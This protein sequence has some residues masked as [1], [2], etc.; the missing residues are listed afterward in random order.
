M[1][2]DFRDNEIMAY[3]FR[4]TYDLLE[5][6]FTGVLHMRFDT[7]PN[8]MN[9][10]VLRGAKTIS[11]QGEFPE[12]QEELEEQAGWEQPEIK[13][14]NDVWNRFNDVIVLAWTDAQN[15]EH[16]R[17]FT[18]SGDPG[19]VTRARYLRTVQWLHG[20]G[21]VAQGQHTATWGNVPIQRRLTYIDIAAYTQEGN[22][23]AA[24]WG[25]RLQW[26]NGEKYYTLAPVLETQI[27]GAGPVERAGR[28]RFIGDAT[29]GC[30]VYCGGAGDQGELYDAIWGWYG[31]ENNTFNVLVWKA[32]DLYRWQRDGRFNPRDFRP[33]LDFATRDWSN[34]PAQRRVEQIQRLIE[35]RTG[36]E[37]QDE[38]GV[39]GNHTGDT[40]RE[41]QRVCYEFII[42]FLQSSEEF[43]G[44][45]LDNPP[46]RQIELAQHMC[47]GNWG[48]DR[49]YFQHPGNILTLAINPRELRW[50]RN[51]WICGPETWKLLECNGLFV[52]LNV[53]VREDVPNVRTEAW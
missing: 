40:L 9:I 34:V 2:E 28:E 51:E 23:V 41:F 4:L 46:N 15:N 3:R 32:W 12:T 36:V 25:K 44:I 45:D 30:T 47:G 8:E 6:F 27:H 52:A 43:R 13:L 21:F 29:A 19:Q 1:P 38:A 53:P 31:M 14:V 26:V 10:I 50:E 39:F 11:P 18:G 22:R 24:G 35:D 49:Q 48:L 5:N 20:Y 16:V 37:L 42:L 7:A 17:A 33:T